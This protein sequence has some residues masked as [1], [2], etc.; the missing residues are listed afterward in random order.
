MRII[1]LTLLLSFLVGLSLNAQNTLTKTAFEEAVINCDSIKG[2]N[3][4][5]ITEYFGNVNYK[6]EMLELVDAKKVVYNRI[7]KELTATGL[8]KFSF[9][10]EIDVKNTAKMQTLRYTVG[11]KILYLE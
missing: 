4:I 7:T 6:S 3:V 1:T 5:G 9:D 11:D 2:N 8:S 10:G